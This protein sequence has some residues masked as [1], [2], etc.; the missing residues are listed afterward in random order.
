MHETFEPPRRLSAFPPAVTALLAANALV[1][2]LQLMGFGILEVRFALWPMGGEGLVRTSQGILRVP[3]FELWQLLSYSFLHGNLTH[4]LFNMF[5]LWMFGAQL[6]NF[7]G[8]KRFGIYYFVCVIG[9]ALVQLAVATEAASRGDVYPTIGA[10]GGVF[11]ILL[12]FGMRFPNQ[13]I[14]LLIPPIPMKAKYFVI[15]YGLLEL[16]LGT[17]GPGDGVAHFAHLGGM[18]T[19]LLL[20][21]YWRG[22]LPIKPRHRIGW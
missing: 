7:W 12:G 8:S 21:F 17:A 6:E 5:A 18:L 15:L 1:F 2:G 10:S 14:V 4:L 20:I 19:G 3:D 22:K 11:G 16:F 9:A 13:R